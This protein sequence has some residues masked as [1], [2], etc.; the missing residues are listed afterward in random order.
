MCFAS[1]LVGCDKRRLLRTCW[2]MGV[3]SLSVSKGEEIPTGSRGSTGEIQRKKGVSFAVS[4]V[5]HGTTCSFLSW[6]VD[7]C[8]FWIAGGVPLVLAVRGWG[9][10]LL[11]STTIQIFQ[12]VTRVETICF[13]IRL[14]VLH[15]SPAKCQHMQ[16][17]DAHSCGA[18]SQRL[19]ARSR[20]NGS[21]AKLPRA[22]CSKLSVQS[23][24]EWKTFVL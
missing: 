8:L 11:F 15:F 14:L 5:F 24:E 9:I 12:D 7:I 4:P 1:F 20:H 16:S 23:T 13:V 22:S 18:Y 6:R 17:H 19:S 2:G 21:S 3:C 10:L